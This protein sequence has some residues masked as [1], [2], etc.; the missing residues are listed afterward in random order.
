MASR[1]FQGRQILLADY[2][3][4]GNTFSGTLIFKSNVDFGLDTDDG[5]TQGGFVDWF[6]LQHFDRFKGKYVPPLTEVETGVPFRG[7]LWGVVVKPDR[8]RLAWLVMAV[9]VFAVAI[10][11]CDLPLTA[12]YDDNREFDKIQAAFEQ[13]PDAFAGVV[14]YVELLKAAHPDIEQLSWTYSWLCITGA[15]GTEVCNDV[16][17]ADKAVLD[18]LPHYVSSVRYYAKDPDRIFVEFNRPEPPVVYAMYAPGD[19]RPGDFA[20]ERGFRS[21]RELGDD[22][23]LL[24]SI[25]DRDA[26]DE[27][28]PAP[29]FPDYSLD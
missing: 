9:V 24:G 29:P 4:T 22:W 21:H 3:V 20:K 7:S 5:I 12:S 16:S 19:D 15:G 28:F 8:G 18:P 17:A 14:D 25:D 1:S 10:A 27:Q 26:I 6:T 13:D 11:G 23:T 2:K